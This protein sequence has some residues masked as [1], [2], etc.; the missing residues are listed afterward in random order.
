M[1]RATNARRCSDRQPAA[2]ELGAR[3][4]KGRRAKLQ[5]QPRQPQAKTS[6]SLGAGPGP[7]QSEATPPAARRN[8]ANRVPSSPK[9]KIS[10][11][12][13]PANGNREFS[14]NRVLTM[15]ELGGNRARMATVAKPTATALGAGK[16]VAPAAAAAAAHRPATA[17]PTAA[18]N[19]LSS[20]VR[21]ESAT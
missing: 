19:G 4:A 12:R 20:A 3:H 1:P 13:A 8:R 17:L 21:T 10:S 7:Q 2:P 16:T 18:A 11:N 14:S 6:V 9:A 5:G 15:H